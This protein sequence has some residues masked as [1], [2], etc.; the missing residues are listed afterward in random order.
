MEITCLGS[1]EKFWLG[2]QQNI[3]EYLTISKLYVALDTEIESSLFLR[4]SVY[5]YLEKP[6]KKN[7]F[8][9]HTKYL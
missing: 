2:S 9:P 7:N 1:L 6:K 3:A 4:W 8:L 5:P